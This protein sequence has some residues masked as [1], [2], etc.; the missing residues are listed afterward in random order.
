MNIYKQ[1][2]SIW[3]TNK[4]TRYKYT[5]NELLSLKVYTDETDFTSKFRQSFWSNV[6]KEIKQEFY[7][8]AI[9]IYSAALYHSRPLPQWDS[10]TTSPTIIYHG[11]H[12]IL[13]VNDRTPKYFGPVS[14]TIAQSV[15]EQ[16]VNEKGTLWNI[17]TTYYN[18][19]TFIV[20]IDV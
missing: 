13:A 18:P 11:I 20:G 12:T 14:T 4:I 6:S 5:F 1:Q 9:N 3:M 2:C 8:W 10:K 19:F 15:A 17:Q 16:F 7:H